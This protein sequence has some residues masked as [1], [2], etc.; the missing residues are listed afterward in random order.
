MDR[1][2]SCF[3]YKYSFNRKRNELLLSNYFE[4]MS[5]MILQIILTL[6]LLMYLLC[7]ECYHLHRI[8]VGG[9]EIYYILASYNNARQQYKHVTDP[10]TEMTL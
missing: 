10:H 6:Q 4:L 2:S 8:C 7:N 5:Y 1:V 3:K 9:T